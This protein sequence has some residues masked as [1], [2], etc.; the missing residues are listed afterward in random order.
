[1]SKNQEKIA[2]KKA[3][4]SDYLKGVKR[5]RIEQRWETAQIKAAGAQSVLDYMVEQ[6]HKFNF[7]LTPEQIEQTEDQIALRQK[8]IKEF[9]MAEKAEYERRLGVIG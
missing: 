7:E 6:F 9:I 8:E 1:M 4:Q 5:Q 2:I 3:E